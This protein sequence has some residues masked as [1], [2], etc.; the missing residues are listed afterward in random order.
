[1]IGCA[2]LLGAF[3][4]VAAGTPIAAVWLVA[5]AAVLIVA[6][7]AERE[8]YETVFPGDRPAGPAEDFRPTD[9]VFDDPT[10]GLRTRVWYDPQTGR[11]V[12]RPD[13]LTRS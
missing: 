10:T 2:A 7:L 6:A 9:E 11:R 1:V 3:G 13:T 8:R 4:A 12:Y 5:S